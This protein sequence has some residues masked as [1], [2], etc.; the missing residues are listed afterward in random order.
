MRKIT[1][2]QC[3]FIDSMDVVK[4]EFHDF[5]FEASG[6]VYS[7]PL[8]ESV[9]IPWMFWCHLLDAVTTVDASWKTW[10]ASN[11]FSRLGRHVRNNHTYSYTYIFSSKTPSTITAT[12]LWLKHHY[13]SMVLRMICGDFLVR[14]SHSPLTDYFLGAHSR[15]WTVTHREHIY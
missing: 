9:Q 4:A 1:F 2:N 12:E 3:R 15:P 10:S 5:T 6:D 7:F 11:L 13:C 14:T 8:L